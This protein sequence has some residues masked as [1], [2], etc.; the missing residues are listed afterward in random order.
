MKMNKLLSIF[1]FAAVATILASCASTKVDRVDPGKVTDYSGYWNDTDVRLA[2]SEIISAFNSSAAIK[3]Y[4]KANGGKVP[5]VIIGSYKNVSD[6]HIDTKILT[7]YLQA[8][9]LEDRNVKFVSSAD[10]RTEL[11]AEREYQQG[12][13]TEATR[14]K[15]KAQT[16]ADYMLM[17]SIRT[18][19]DTKDGGKKTARTYY[20]TTEIVDIETSEILW[21]NDNHSIKKII[22]KSSTRS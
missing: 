13:A 8:Q 21:K 2:A 17:G 6:E 19:I 10:T 16:G 5:V 14:A 20:I 15:L 12:H 18:I 1:A 22:T 11:D 3:D 4:P 9:L 7:D